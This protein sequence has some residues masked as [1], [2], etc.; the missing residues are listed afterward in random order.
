MCRPSLSSISL[1]LSRDTLANRTAAPTAESLHSN[2]ALRCSSPEVEDQQEETRRVSAMAIEH[3]WSQKDAREPKYS[4]LRSSVCQIPKIA[5]LGIDRK[6]RVQST[7]EV[8]G[9]VD[10]ELC[11]WLPFSH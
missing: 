3:R 6:A 4:T 11:R 8:E 2:F 7:S 10:Y 1:D 5:E 9:E